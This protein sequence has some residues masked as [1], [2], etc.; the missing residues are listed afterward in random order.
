MSMKESGRR[1]GV[2]EEYLDE[3][4]K[5]G[6]EGF[7]TKVERKRLQDVHGFSQVKSIDKVSVRKFESKKVIKEVNDVQHTASAHIQRKVSFHQ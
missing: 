2:T 7:S 6:E 4:D 1:K 3:E 5:L